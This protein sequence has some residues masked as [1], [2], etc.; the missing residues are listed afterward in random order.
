MRGGRALIMHKLTIIGTGIWGT[1]LAVQ[2]ANH[3]YK[4]NL[5]GRNHALTAKMATARF[6]TSYLPN[7]KLP[8]KIECRQDFDVAIADGDIILL[9][10]PTASI[11]QIVK[12]VAPLLDRHKGIAWACKGI[13]A[14]SGRWIHDIV[15]EIVNRDLP[16]AAVS[17]PSFAYEVAMDL[18]TALVVACKR[19]SF[20]DTLAQMLHG[21]K[22]RVYT[23]DDIIGVECGGALKNVIAIAAGISEGLGLGENAK[24]ALV[25]RGIAEV[26]RFTE[27][28]G[29]RTETIIGL[30]GIGDIVLSC[31]SSSSRNQ[32]FGKMIVKY[33]STQ[34][35]QEK[36]TKIIEGVETAKAVLKMASR[37]RIE[38]PICEKI[39]SILSDRISAEQAVEQ[40]L[41]RQAP[42]KAS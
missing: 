38:M 23:T 35:A 22:L 29:G 40:L 10:T 42:F 26:I 20:A 27:A 9:V 39:A 4:V 41:Q 21:G 36:N 1:A 13:D 11:R 8:D 14:D 19:K 31:S 24:A 16:L 34:K 6:N 37:Q 12:R 18:P 5:W 15:S 33:G 3:G 28:M 30:A 32:N 2:F 25:T 7:I 17:G